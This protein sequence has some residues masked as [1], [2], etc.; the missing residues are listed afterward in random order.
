MENNQEI[1]EKISPK[2]FTFNQQKKQL[3]LSK[4]NVKKN[5]YIKKLLELRFEEPK[6]FFEEIINNQSIIIGKKKS[7]EKQFRIPTPKHLKKP[8]LQISKK[9][10]RFIKNNSLSKNV[11]NKSYIPKKTAIKFSSENNN[12]NFNINQNK[13]K[14]EKIDF[15]QNNTSD[16]KNPKLRL[17]D[18]EKLEEI[19]KKFKKPKN[20]IPSFYYTYSNFNSKKSEFSH[21]RTQSNLKNESKNENCFKSSFMNSNF[22]INDTRKISNSS[23]SSTAYIFNSTK[24]IN[25]LF[26]GKVNFQSNKKSVSYKKIQPPLSPL[27]K[28]SRENSLIFNKRKLLSEQNQYLSTTI[29]KNKNKKKL[30]TEFSTSQLRDALANQELI[31]LSQKKYNKKYNLLCNYMCRKLKTPS[32]N[33]LINKIEDY[34]ISKDVREKVDKEVGK[35]FLD[36]NYSWYKDLRNLKNIRDYFNSN[37]TETIRDPNYLLMS[38]KKSDK[39]MIEKIKMKLPKKHAKHLIN[40]IRNIS[41]NYGSLS[42]N[43]KNLY[44]IEYNHCKNASG[45]ILLMNF[46]EMLNKDDVAD[47]LFVEDINYKKYHKNSIYK[48]DNK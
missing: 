11:S 37:T 9:K 33:L 5:P 38:P 25:P 20:N 17:I 18:K 47:K 48:N 6:T 44:K 30:N 7:P 36:T 14:N 24:K 22:N 2:K 23:E 13:K 45:K 43:G 15:N 4:I 1:T 10:T 34:R 28:L 40:E 35:I 46:E 26:N 41:N 3:I 8:T 39:K 12:L 32:K 27:S 21:F 19:F 29:K 42:V 16:L 31:L